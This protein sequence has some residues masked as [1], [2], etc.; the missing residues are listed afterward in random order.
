MLQTLLLFSC[1]ALHAVMHVCTAAGK[2]TCNLTCFMI[3]GLT[4]TM[5]VNLWQNLTGATCAVPTYPYLS[6]PG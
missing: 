5:A 4:E 3:T 6:R 2:I 1:L